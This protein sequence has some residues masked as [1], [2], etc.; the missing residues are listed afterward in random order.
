MPQTY[1]HTFTVSGR[2]VAQFDAGFGQGMDAAAELSERLIPQVDPDDDPVVYLDFLGQ[3]TAE[4]PLPV[5]VENGSRYWD[6]AKLRGFSGTLV[7]PQYPAGIAA[8]LRRARGGNR[9]LDEPHTVD[10]DFKLLED[11]D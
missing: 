3:N 7:T 4:H 6:L 11:G 9:W 1:D 2:T 8:V 10:C 5:L